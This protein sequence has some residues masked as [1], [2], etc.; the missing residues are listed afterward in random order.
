MMKE[1]GNEKDKIRLTTIKQ[2][3]KLNSTSAAKTNKY[4]E[5]VENTNITK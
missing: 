2:F 3:R 5:L 1:I 4:N